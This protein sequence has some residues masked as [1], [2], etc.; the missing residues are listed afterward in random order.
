MDLSCAVL[1]WK[2]TALAGISD[3][4]VLKNEQRLK[5]PIILPQIDLCHFGSL[6]L[7]CRRLIT[8][9]RALH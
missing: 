7:T 2:R 8:L 4:L 3:N 1:P 9:A 6:D 5:G